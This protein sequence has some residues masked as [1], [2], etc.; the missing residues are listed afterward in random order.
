MEL[1]M[2]RRHLNSQWREKYEMSMK[3]LIYNIYL[4]K[5]NNHL[6]DKEWT[7]KGANELF[8]L[9][10]RDFKE[11][12]QWVLDFAETQIQTQRTYRQ[13]RSWAD[14]GVSFN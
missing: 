11:E 7:K 4:E 12:V 1:P 6:P 5:C 10:K 13:P 2:K 3:D 9:V 8:M 14:W